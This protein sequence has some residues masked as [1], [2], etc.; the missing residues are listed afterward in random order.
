MLNRIKVED[1]VRL[2]PSNVTFEEGDDPMDEED[3]PES[4]ESVGIAGRDSVFPEHNNFEDETR[5]QLEDSDGFDE[6]SLE[7]SDMEEVEIKVVMEE[8][9]VDEVEE[10]EV[11][12]DEVEEDEVEEVEEEERW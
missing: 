3:D 8:D 5:N 4:E 6:Y 9:E 11:E 12:E 1:S 2:V 7:N 10:D